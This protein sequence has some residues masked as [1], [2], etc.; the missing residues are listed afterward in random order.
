MWCVSSWVTIYTSPLRAFWDFSLVI[1]LEAMKDGRGGSWR[2]STMSCKETTSHETI[3]YS[4]GKAVLT[5]SN[6]SGRT[7]STGKTD[8][9]EFCRFF[10][11]IRVF[12]YIPIPIIRILF[13]P[14]QCSHFNSRPWQ[15][16]NSFCCKSV[17]YRMRF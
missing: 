11:V 17:T 3:A 4:S 7:I 9:A 12:L 15:V 8:S 14:K 1:G 5:Y 16:G 2:E 6:R 10:S 13:H